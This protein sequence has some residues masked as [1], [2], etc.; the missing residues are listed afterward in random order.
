MLKE[1]FTLLA[2]ASTFGLVLGVL[3]A[4]FYQPANEWLKKRFSSSIET[5]KA[6]LDLA[7]AYYE[8]RFEVYLRLWQ[9]TQNCLRAI[10]NASNP[11]NPVSPDDARET[12]VDLKNYYWDQRPLLS[13][14][15]FLALDKANRLSHVAVSQ[16]RRARDREWDGRRRHWD[17]MVH[18]IRHIQGDLLQALDEDLQHAGLAAMILGEAGFSE[19]EIPASSDLDSALHDLVTWVAH[20]EHTM[21]YVGKSY[22]QSR[23][24]C[25]DGIDM[26]T[27]LEYALAEGVF[28]EQSVLD[29]SFE[30]VVPSLSVNRENDVVK[31]VLGAQ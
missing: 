7:A 27:L 14:R 31:R 4:L 15:V 28:V 13:L 11:S 25:P 30:K 19:P 3:L 22:V 29:E 16:A 23:F 2:E 24:R 21:R 5:K 18:R 6:Q 8:K 26:A 12:L 10:L 17:D 1:I 20:L 9:K